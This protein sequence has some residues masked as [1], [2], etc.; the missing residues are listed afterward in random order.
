MNCTVQ[1]LSSMCAELGKLSV[2]KNRREN[3]S[4]VISYQ[5]KVIGKNEI[6][7]KEDTA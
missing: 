2:Q 4:S 6:E 1:N 3:Q 5:L 7:M